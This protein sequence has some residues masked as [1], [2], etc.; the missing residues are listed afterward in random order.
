MRCRF[1]KMTLVTNLRTC[2]CSACLGRHRHILLACTTLTRSN[3]PACSRPPL[4]DQPEHNQQEASAS[5]PF[6]SLKWFTA[7][8]LELRNT[9]NIERMSAYVSIDVF[10]YQ[11]KTS[12]HSAKVDGCAHFHICTDHVTS[13]MIIFETRSGRRL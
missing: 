2:T 5:L 8:P 7:R 11:N 9:I 3:D 13:R 4:V 6:E 10:L 12:R 1:L